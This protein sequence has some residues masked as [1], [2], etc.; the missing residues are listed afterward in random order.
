[1]C[2]KEVGINGE[3]NVKMNCTALRKGGVGLDTFGL[4]QGQVMVSCELLQFAVNIHKVQRIC[5]L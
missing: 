4:G 1:M 5:L 2:L 3:D